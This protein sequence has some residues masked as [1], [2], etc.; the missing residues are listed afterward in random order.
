MPEVGP[1]KTP[2]VHDLLASGSVGAEFSMPVLEHMLNG[3][4]FCKMLYD[5]SRACDF[6]YLYTNRA[7]H[8][9]TGLGEVQNK[10]ASEVIPGIQKLDPLLI[11]TYGRVAKGGEPERFEMYVA[12]LRQ[13]FEVSVFSPCPEHFV[14]VFDVVTERKNAEIVLRRKESM[15]ARTEA[16]A[17]IGSWEWHV[18]TDTVTWSDELFRLFQRNPAEGA[19]PFADQIGLYH[20]EDFQRLSLAARAA[21]KDGKSFEIDLRIVR[22]DGQT[23]L[24]RGR[25]LAELGPDGG[26]DTLYGS[27]EDITE[28]QRAEQEVLHYR[29]H[30]QELVTERTAE[31]EMALR[32]AATA[33]LAK[34]QFLANMSH[35]IRTPLGAIAGMARLVRKGTLSAEQA[36]KLDK[37]EA[38]T[39]HVI[40]TI[41]DILDLSKIEADKLLL[42]QGPVDIAALMDTAVNIIH[43][44]AQE[45]KLALHTQLATMPTGLMGD[46]TRIRQALL[47]YVSNA[48]KFT[49]A[50]GV[51]LRATVLE[52]GVANSLIR[53]E[54]SD[55]GIGVPP[56]NLNRLFGL[57]EQVDSTITRRFGGTGLGLAITKR[58]A[59]AMGGEVGVHSTPGQGST[60][61]FT[62]RLSKALHEAQTLSHATGEDL[63]DLI[64]QRSAGHCVLLAEDDAFN[65]E[66]GTYLLSEVGLQVEI[67]KDGRQ[68]LEMAARKRY[69]LI[70]M[71]VQMPHMDGLEACRKIRQLA[72]DN[73]VPIWAMTANAFA[74]DRARCLAAGMDAFMSKPVQVAVLYQNLLALLPH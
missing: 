31:L 68:A 46:A 45:K 2:L 34:S 63:V 51:T 35:E 19:P 55:T 11:E 73:D 29:D 65:Q 22:S 62:A 39:N 57:F 67:A 4:A 8:A 36:D 10:R 20:P 27:L 58:L 25:V 43:A 14:A 30:L 6:V 9:Q 53:F 60:F 69:T 59:N 70:L 61:W 71:D 64:K 13:W 24:C 12:G 47:N 40:A 48:I 42:E 41:N 18:P 21:M 44:Q 7:F 54:V 33:N 32:G 15:L 26:A 1:I 38:A 66:I 56:E 3:I 37:L 52:D 50:G 49:E 72:A 17:H 23:R 28:R 5:D 16:L 74:E